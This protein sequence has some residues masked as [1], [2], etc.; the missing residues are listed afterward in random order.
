MKNKK[1]IFY[2]IISLIL[3]SLINVNFMQSDNI[4]K[5]SDSDIIRFETNYGTFDVKVFPDKAPKTAARIKE[6]ASSGFYNGIIFHRVID[7][8][9][10]QGGDPTGTGTGG[11]GQ[12]IPDEFDN[13]LSHDKAGVVAMANSGRKNSQDSQFYITLAPVQFLDGKYTIF[14][15]VVAGLDIVKTIGK[16]PTGPGDKP[17][18]DVIMTK[19]YLL[20][21]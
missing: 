8:F 2:F 16:V 14:G 6:L 17:V 4:E 5:K 13:G 18:K 11:S 20:D 21:E 9:V 7:Q 12:P 3:Y 15:E 19:V 10:I 1:N